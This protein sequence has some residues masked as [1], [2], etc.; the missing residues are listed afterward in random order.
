[1]GQLVLG[2]KALPPNQVP[3]LKQQAYKDQ[4]LI[5]IDK[6]TRYRQEL[7][8]ARQMLLNVREIDYN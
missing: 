7:E 5:K 6:M 2:N 4:W 8:E 3:D 1:M